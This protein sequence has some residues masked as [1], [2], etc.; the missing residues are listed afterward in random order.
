[1]LRTRCDA[2]GTHSFQGTSGRKGREIDQ[3]TAYSGDNRVGDGDGDEARDDA[4]TPDY[5]PPNL[6]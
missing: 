1:M 2:V 4:P 6:D 5:N 3:W